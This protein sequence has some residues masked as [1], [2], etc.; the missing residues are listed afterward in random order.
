MERILINNQG[1]TKARNI[2]EKIE[3]GLFDLSHVEN[4]LIILRSFSGGNKIFREVADL[5]AHNDER[6]RGIVNESLEA[7]YLSMRFLNDYTLAGKGIDLTQ[8]F[9]LYVKKHMGYQ[10]DRCVEGKLQSE[11]KLTKERLKTRLNKL[12]KDNRVNQTTVLNDK[13]SRE[14]LLALNYICSF[15]RS[16]YAFNGD[17]LIKEIINVLRENQIVHTE[18]AIQQQAEKINICIMALL[19]NTNFKLSGNSGRCAIACENSP[20]MMHNL[21][22]NENGQNIA[23][24]AEALTHGILSIHGEFLQTVSG[25]DVTWVFPI[26]TANHVTEKWCEQNIFRK[27]QEIVGNH[28]ITFQIA[29]FK[30]DIILNDNFKLELC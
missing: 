20:L 24:P 15:I 10:I 25:V 8:P 17:Q 3:K 26:F 7:A 19:H 23:V 27:E 21:G 30:G 12:F 18:N 13:I 4:L 1:K 14:T 29:D 9:P 11:F 6:D 28:T 2:V 22:T 5:V 16:E